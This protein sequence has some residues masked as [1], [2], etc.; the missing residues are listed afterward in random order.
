MLSALGTPLW[1][2]QKETQPQVKISSETALAPAMDFPSTVFKTRLEADL[3][4]FFRG[5]PRWKV[6]RNP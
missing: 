6:L 3:A 2:K 4:D 1:E 5:L